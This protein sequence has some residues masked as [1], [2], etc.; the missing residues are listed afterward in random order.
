[1]IFSIWK[2]ERRA[3][4]IAAFPAPLV[5]R[6]VPSMSNRRIFIQVVY[7]F[8]G[9]AT[10]GTELLPGDDGI[11]GRENSFGVRSGGLPC[12][13]S[14]LRPESLGLA[15]LVL[16]CQAERYCLP[17]CSLAGNS[18]GLAAVSACGSVDSLIVKYLSPAWFKSQLFRVTDG[19]RRSRLLRRGGQDEAA[20]FVY[21]MC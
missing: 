12:L 9:G 19:R 3:C 8:V 13:Y 1:M 4:S 15:D 14:G 21:R 20:C 10:V 18:V 16:D 11:V 7:F 2:V 17:G 6:M 5:F